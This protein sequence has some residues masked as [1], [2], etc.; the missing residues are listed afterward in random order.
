ME[1][2]RQYVF[3]KASQVLIDLV[4][5]LVA[6]VAAYG[7]RFE[8]L[9]T[10]HYLTQMAVLLPVIM[11]A[12]LVTFHLFSI[13]TIVW[14]Y[15]SIRDVFNLSLATLP[16]TVVLLVIRFL[17]PD[18]LSAYRVPLGVIS[19]EFLLVLF[20]TAG[21]RALRRLVLEEKKRESL[22]RSAGPAKHVLLIGAGDAGNLVLREMKQRVDLGLSVVG[23][24]DDDPE[25]HGRNIQGVGVLGGTADIPKIAARLG[26]DE[27]VI[28]I[29]NAS[30]KDIRRV[31]GLCESAA[32]K[33]KIVPGLLETL[34]DNV[35]ITKVREIDIE[36]L[37]GRSVFQLEKHLPGVTEVYRGKRILVTGAGGS[38]GSE[39]CRQ[40]A[41]LGPAEIVLLDKDENSIFEID[42]DLKD[43]RLDGVAIRPVISNIKNGDRLKVLFEKHRPEIVFHAAAHK[44]VPLME[45]NVAEAILN[46]VLG[47]INVVETAAAAGVERF[48]FISTDKAVNPTSVMGATK[49]LGEVV[50]QSKAKSSQTK[51]ACVR[52]G[53]VLGSRGSAVP[54]F[55]KQIARGGPVTVTHPEM[56]RYFMSI[57]EAVHL[58]IQAGTV[59]DKGEI[60]VLDM[61][62]P[63]KIVD[64]VKTLI[65]LS[66]HREDDIEIK[67]VGARPG[68]KLYEELLIDEERT[69]STKFERIFIAPPVESL[70][71][72]ALKGTN[73]IIEAAT[74]GDVESILRGLAEM[75]IGYRR[76]A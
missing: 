42:A 68:E 43:R 26:V 12:R 40:L 65:R 74:A 4:V 53:N 37:L 50:V 14:R 45:A 56:R 35:K 28:T 75:G 29:A 1:R 76:T 48:I 3:T 46:N 36:D 15:V 23:F 19:L 64:L 39:L 24:V 27:A 11:V 57:P 2:I 13:Y 73:A 55:R 59:G 38:I 5:F 54:L 31:V 10:G 8:I 58:I 67:F 41:A 32:L 30:S 62:Q 69:K 22:G 25:K 34:D 17:G 49:K 33:V 44:H 51:F 61:G 60:F 70:N 47:T 20:G 66:G 63:I 9:P 21:A 6:W 18:S 7:A 72:S 52:F 16:V 71:G